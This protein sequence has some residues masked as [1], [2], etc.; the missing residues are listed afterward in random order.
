MHGVT[1]YDCLHRGLRIP[2]RVILDIDRAL[3]YARDKGLNPHDVHGKNVMMHEGQG[4]VAD[5]SDFLERE[6]DSAWDDFKRFYFW[7]YRPLLA[8]VRVPIPLS[9][10]D[11]SRF[12]YRQLRGLLRREKS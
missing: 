2:V 1:L 9:L 8:P 6:P 4:L 11:F 5:I 10:L 3:D 7:I 12:V